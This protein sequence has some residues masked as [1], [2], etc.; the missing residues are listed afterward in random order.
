MKACNYLICLLM[1]LLLGACS[2]NSNAPDTVE[3]VWHEKKVV[4]ILPQSDGMG[5]HWQRVFSLFS[6]NAENAFR[7]QADGIRLSFEYH[8][9]STEDIDAL[10]E[11]FIT[12]LQGA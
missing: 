7:G 8:D 2:D 5:E 11:E 3:T 1:M 6:G 12:G 9:E 4:V 10:A